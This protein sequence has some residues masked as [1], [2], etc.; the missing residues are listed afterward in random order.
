MIAPTAPE[1]AAAL[2]ELD[3]DGPPTV[4]AVIEKTAPGVHTPVP[5]ADVVVGR[6]F[7]GDQ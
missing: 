6:G 4:A 3:Y 7:A 1:L 2:S 5:V